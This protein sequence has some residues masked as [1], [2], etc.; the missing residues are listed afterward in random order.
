MYIYTQ[1]PTTHPSIHL[2]T[3]IL[4]T[5]P[6][7]PPPPLLQSRNEVVV[8]AEAILIRAIGSVDGA[9]GGR[10]DIAARVE[11]L[12]LLGAGP[13]A[14]DGV[15]VEAGAD[16]L[17]GE[18]L[19]AA[20]DADGALGPARQHHGVVDGVDGGARAPRHVARARLGRAAVPE[21]PREAAAVARRHGARVAPRLERVDEG[22][23]QRL[24][25][26]VRVRVRVAVLQD[27]L[28]EAFRPARADVVA[29]AGVVLNGE[30]D[31]VSTFFTP[32]D[33]RGG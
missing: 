32:N 11:Q 6:S 28:G 10:D 33:E 9:R 18:G 12:D 4:K 3:H 21:R 23:D 20:R 19:A 26:R 2:Y 27:V 14:R 1:H 24:P 22:R 15:V 31:G 13:E 17:L 29:L 16:G 8:V 25:A 30:D 7:S 5:P